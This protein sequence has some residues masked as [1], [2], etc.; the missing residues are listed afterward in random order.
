MM[1]R[2]QVINLPAWWGATTTIVFG[3]R[4]DPSFLGTSVIKT[5][6]RE[7]VVIITFVAKSSPTWHEPLWRDQAIN[8]QRLGDWKHILDGAPTWTRV[9][10][11]YRYYGKKLMYRVG[12]SLTHFFK[13]LHFILATCVPLL[14]KNIILLVLAIDCKT[15]VW[16]V[17][18]L[19]ETV[20]EY[21]DGML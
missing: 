13:F 12:I 4:G 16:W 21:L 3:G 19:D 15:L 5:V 6:S 20:V 8:R 1:A 2:Q 18:T 17:G 9:A 11:S 7:Q 14:S 10:F